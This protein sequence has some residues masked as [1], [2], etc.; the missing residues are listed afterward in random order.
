M[1][2]GSPTLIQGWHFR[3]GAIVAPFEWTD[4]R[5]TSSG[6]SCYPGDIH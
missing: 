6:S 2:V 5:V 1:G 4:P 3:S